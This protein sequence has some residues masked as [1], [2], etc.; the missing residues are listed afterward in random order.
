MALSPWLS[1]LYRYNGTIHS[2]PYFI[3]KT[4]MHAG[5]ALYCE[6]LYLMPSL[7]PTKNSIQPGAHEPPNTTLSHFSSMLCDQAIFKNVCIY[8]CMCVFGMAEDYPIPGLIFSNA[9]PVHSAHGA[10]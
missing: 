3:K 5:K 4:M 9:G 6:C 1:G 8:A 7:H 2:M 10:F